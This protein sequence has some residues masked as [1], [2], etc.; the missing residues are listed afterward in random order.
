MT[1]WMSPCTP[2]DYHADRVVN[3]TTPKLTSLHIT[4]AGASGL[5]IEE[6]NYV[7]ENKKSPLSSNNL[8][9]KTPYSFGSRLKLTQPDY[10]EF[11]SADRD[12]SEYVLHDKNMRRFLFLNK[13]KGGEGQ[14]RE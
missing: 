9:L 11:L 10:I 8:K 7:F 12:M 3:L 6:S 4:S 5:L 14:K 13:R 1:S 2:L